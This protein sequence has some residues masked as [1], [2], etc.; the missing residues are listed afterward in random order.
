SGG[1]ATTPTTPFTSGW[2]SDPGPVTVHGSRVTTQWLQ[3]RPARRSRRAALALEQQV[4]QQQ[5]HLVDQ[6][7]HEQ[8]VPLRI[9]LV[10]LRPVRGDDRERRV[11]H[12]ALATSPGARRLLPPPVG[13]PDQPRQAGWFVL[14]DARNL[15]RRVGP[16]RARS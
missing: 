11:R 16:K 1:S 6:Q 8:D 3:L 9:P 4:V 14:V 13:T 15:L 7:H 2:A 12:A 10:E 5:R